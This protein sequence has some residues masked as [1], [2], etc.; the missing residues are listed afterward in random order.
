MHKSEPIYGV[1]Q[2]FGSLDP[3]PGSPGPPNKPW[4]LARYVSGEHWLEF[5]F[6]G[7]GEKVAE[8]VGGHPDLQEQE[9][10]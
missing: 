8:G 7:T 6:F 9:P 2:P 1:K 4:R 10:E 3:R 5:D